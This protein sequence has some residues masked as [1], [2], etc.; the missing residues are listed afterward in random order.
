MQR[1]PLSLVLLQEAQIEEG[2]CAFSA[3][4]YDA[5]A[6]I[7]IN[8]RFYGV[9]TASVKESSLAEAYLTESSEGF[10]GPHK[11]LLLTTYALPGGEDLLLL[12]VHAINFREQRIYEEELDVLMK[13]A[14]AHKGPMIVA[15]DFNAWSQKRTDALH[16]LRETLSLHIAAFDK[17]KVKSFM[18]YPL[19]FILYRG[20]QCVETE[21]MTN[22]DISDHHPLLA[23]FRLSL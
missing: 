15:G 23:T 7:E 20:L 17:G 1:Y 4:S 11:S 3:F 18:G 10:V 9:L 16:M 2:T 13:K 19:D 14:T 5:A 22:H 21:I 8:K 12:N 6:N